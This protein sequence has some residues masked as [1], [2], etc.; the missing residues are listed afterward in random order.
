[1]KNKIEVCEKLRPCLVKYNK[2]DG[3]TYYKKALFHKWVEYEDVTRIDRK[4]VKGLVEYE[5]GT[6][7]LMYIS[8]I[9]FLDPQHSKYDFGDVENE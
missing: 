1:M 6:V 8:L 5:D 4:G 9:I 3:K 7:E 2:T